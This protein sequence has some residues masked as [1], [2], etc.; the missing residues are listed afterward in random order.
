MIK[1]SSVADPGCLSKIRIFFIL[2]QNFSHPDPGFASKNLRIL[3]Q[4]IVCKLSEIWSGLF[5]P[6]PDPD[7]LPIPNPGSGW[8]KRHRIPDPDPQHWSCL[9]GFE[10][11]SGVR[12]PGREG[13]C[14][15]GPAGA[16]W[17][18]GPACSLNLAR[19]GPF[20]TGRW[21]GSLLFGEVRIRTW[22][23][24]QNN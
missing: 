18:D 21:T 8:S 12:F 10:M 4:K 23:C 20:F 15:G 5:I 7:F 19:V 9:M 11:L 6:D 13:S 22:A 16:S 1:L 14:K 24:I 2:D 17:Q 3:T